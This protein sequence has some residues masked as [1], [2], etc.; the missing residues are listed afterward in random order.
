MLM[1]MLWNS[2]N[3]FFD[4]TDPFEDMDRMMNQFF[5]GRD[6]TPSALETTKAMKTDVIEG[7]NEYRLEAELPGFAKEDIKVDMKDG[8]MTIHA[9]HSENNDEKDENG[10]YIR[11]ERR[12]TSYQRSF[13]V[14]TELKPEDISAKYENGVLTLTI[15]KKE[16]IQQK[17][18]PKRIEVK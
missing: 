3:S 4:F 10:K 15:P 6:T 11:R 7:E 2:D 5:A 12:S 17:E 8:I 18:E 1:P 9:A 13:N 14:G 16:V